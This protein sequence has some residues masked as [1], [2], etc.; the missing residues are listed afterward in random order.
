MLGKGRGE[1]L[2][3]GQ[4]NSPSDSFPS[5]MGRLMNIFQFHFI[6]SLSLIYRGAYPTLSLCDL[7]KLPP[8]ILKIWRLLRCAAPGV[9]SF[10]KTACYFIG[11]YPRF[12]RIDSPNPSF[13]IAEINFLYLARVRFLI[14]KISILPFSDFVNRFSEKK[15][16][17]MKLSKYLT[18]FRQVVYT[19]CN[20]WLFKYYPAVVLLAPSQHKVIR[21]YLLRG[22]CRIDI[23]YLPAVDA[24][25]AL[26]DIAARVA[27]RGTQPGRD[28]QT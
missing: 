6:T 4:K 19:L 11:P 22:I 3:K 20:K 14:C 23:G 8:E 2:E 18:Q 12:L 28:E 13:V 7:C 1:D 25:T 17:K 26:L 21:L 10:R 27:P 15:M 5:Q 24:H 16:I 9:G